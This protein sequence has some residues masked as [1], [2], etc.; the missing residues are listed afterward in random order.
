MGD[1]TCFGATK[2]SAGDASAGEPVLERGHAFGGLRSAL[3]M[4]IRE[5]V[6]QQ[7]WPMQL[8]M[9][10]ADFREAYNAAVAELPATAR[11]RN[12]GSRQ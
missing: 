4:L 1:G 10:H 12:Q 7:Q 3:G 6:P 2:A 5:M 8:M 11:P 9:E